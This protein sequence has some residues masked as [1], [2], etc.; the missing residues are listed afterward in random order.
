M[1]NE[2]RFELSRGLGAS[3]RAAGRGGLV[4]LLAAG[5]L[6]SAGGCTTTNS[7][8]ISVPLPPSRIEPEPSITITPEP[9]VIAPPHL[10]AVAAAPVGRTVLGRPIRCS[11]YGTGD[12]TVLVLGGIH[13]N[14]PAGVPLCEQLGTFLAGH[15]EVLAGKQVVVVPATNP[16]GLAANQRGNAHGVDV[17]RNFDAHNR[18]AA[19]TNGPRAMSE[20][21]SQY[22][23]EL[24]R[25]YRP[26]RIVAVHQPLAC[27]DY[28]GPAGELA[29]AV[30]RAC[31]LPIRKLGA[32]PGSLGSYAGLEKQIAIVTVELPKTATVLGAS[33][34]WR[35]Y[36]QALLVA[37]NFREGR[38]VRA[39]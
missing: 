29:T 39:K 7:S 17:N 37:V 22:I 3:R 9:P 38:P 32:L 18:V 25:H 21:E 33:E 10:P 16:D 2:A 36:G 15:S 30:S 4:A 19:K 31:G 1:C 6:L 13:G 23:A 27:V 12:E 5:L 35:L 20:P 26:A 24:I 8:D 14:E 11:V 28:D 34:L